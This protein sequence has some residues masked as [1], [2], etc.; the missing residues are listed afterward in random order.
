MTNETR[1]AAIIGELESAGLTCLVM[2][3]H[4]V[5]YYGFHRDTNDFELHLAP[6]HWDNLTE[7]LSRTRLFGGDSL[8]EGESWRPSAFRRFQVGTLASGQEEWLEFWMHNHLL[9]PFGEIFERREVGLYGGREI[10]FLSLP[11]LIRSKETERK[12]DWEDIE[13]LEGFNDARNFAAVAAGRLPLATALAELRSRRGFETAQ[14]RGHLSDLEIVKLALESTRLSMTQAYLLPCCPQADPPLASV[15]IEPVLLN[16][17][18]VTPPASRMHLGLVEMIRRQYQRAAR[19]LIRRTRKR[20]G[21]RPKPGD[22]PLAAGGCRVIIR[23]GRQLAIS[24]S[25]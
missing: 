21:V 25:L 18:R 12:R 4:A 7:C 23:L 16:K 10:S 22:D 6:D 13:R 9:A 17:L 15:P 5:R 1:L 3:G 14:Q 8:V 24:R 11:D 2:G 19:R 20:F